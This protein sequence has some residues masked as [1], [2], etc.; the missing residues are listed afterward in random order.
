MREKLWE[1]IYEDHALLV[2]R[3]AAGLAVESRK[4]TVPD[5]ERELKNE[6]ARRGEAPEIF[7]INRLDQPV[8]GLVCAAKTKEAAAALSGQLRDGRM[9]KSYLA[10]VTGEVPEKGTLTDWLLRD[11]KTNTTRVVPEGTKGAKRAELHFQRSGEQEAAVELVTGRHHQIRVQ[12]SHAGMPIRGDRKYGGAPG[13]AL[14][15]CACRLSFIHPE[16]GERV[17]FMAE[18]SWKQTETAE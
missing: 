15:L 8:E 2:V 9:K 4:S 5:L 10:C 6:R 3:K 7:L 13:N 18:P 17:T 14:M 1:V 16:S 11:P 12:L